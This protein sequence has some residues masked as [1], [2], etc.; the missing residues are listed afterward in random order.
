MSRGF[1]GPRTIVTTDPE[2]DDLNS[3]LRLLLYANEIDIVGLVSRRAG[4]TTRAIPRR[5]S[6]R[7]GGP[8]RAASST[9]TRP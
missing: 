7:T 5:A 4:S 6:R 2:L 3:M 9:S 8:R 1:A